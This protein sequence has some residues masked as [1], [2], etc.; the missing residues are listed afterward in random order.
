MVSTSST[1]M[2]ITSSALSFPR[3]R[4]R[5]EGRSSWQCGYALGLENTQLPLL[6]LVEDLR[7]ILLNNRWLTWCEVPSPWRV[8]SGSIGSGRACLDGRSL[9]GSIRKVSI[10]RRRAHGRN[11]GAYVR[12]ASCIRDVASHPASVSEGRN[13]ITS[14]IHARY[15]SLSAKILDPEE[16]RSLSQ[17]KPKALRT[18]TISHLVHDVFNGPVT[19]TSVDWRFASLSASRMAS[20]SSGQKKAEPAHT[21]SVLYEST[22]WR[23]CR[24]L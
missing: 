15:S 1:S 18:K 14:V 3:A 21:Y 22:L 10:S 4:S 16:V 5:A 2:S 23:P 20:S 8:G 19:R 9:K 7:R 17:Y 24:L 13:R 11:A 6:Y 12:G